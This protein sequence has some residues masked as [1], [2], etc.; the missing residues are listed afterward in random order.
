MKGNILFYL[1][2]GGEISKK[3]GRCL[4]WWLR[5][6]SH[7]KCV[8][9][10]LQLLTNADLRGQEGQVAGTLPHAWGPCLAL[11]APYPALAWL[12]WVLGGGEE[13]G[14]FHASTRKW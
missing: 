6:M 9:A 4:A 2:G 3:L 11:P 10:Q 7:L 8:G 1:F 12:W 5:P 14:I 13:D